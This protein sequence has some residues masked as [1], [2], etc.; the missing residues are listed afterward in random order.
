[1]K[2][3]G[4]NQEGAR[5]SKSKQARHPTVGTSLCLNIKKIPLPFVLMCFLR[6][7]MSIITS[8]HVYRLTCQKHSIDI[9]DDVNLVS[10]T[11]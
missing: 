11:T 7:M 6:C 4:A 10:T 9:M 2:S 1:M 5:Q 8:G 3:I